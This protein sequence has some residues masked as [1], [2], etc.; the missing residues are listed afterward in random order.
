MMG[1]IPY[2]HGVF[3][4]KKTLPEMKETTYLA[5]MNLLVLMKHLQE[6]C[7]AG[8]TPPNI[9]KH[10]KPSLNQG[11]AMAETLFVG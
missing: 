6:S 8:Q 2:H 9:H 3:P 10:A 5:G 7:M 4:K 1:V 11:K